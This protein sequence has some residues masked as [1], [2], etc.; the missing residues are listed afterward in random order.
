MILPVPEG[1]RIAMKR[2]GI[3]KINLYGCSLYLD[4]VDLAKARGVDPQGLDTRSFSNRALNPP[5]EDTITMGTNAAKAMLSDEDK[6]SIGLLIVGTST[7]VDF[8]KPISTNIHRALGLSPNV[9][10]YEI[11][12]GC[13]GGTAAVDAAVNWIASGTNHGKKALIIAT[14]SSRM[15]LGEEE[16]FSLGCGAVAMLV[17]DEPRIVEYELGKKGTWTQD[18]YDIFG[19]TP[20]NEMGNGALSLATY[21]DALEAAYRN[22]EEKAGEKIDFDTYF[23]HLIYHA[24]SPRMSFQAYRTHCHAVGLRQKSAIT[25]GYRSKVA[26]SQHYAHRTGYTYNAANFV[27]LCSL[28]R[29]LG[30]KKA[31]DRVGFFCYGSGAIGEF[32]SALIC[33]D[34]SGSLNPGI[35]NALDQRRRVSVD[36]YENIERSRQQHIDNPNFTPDF[37]L[38][39]GWYEE[40]YKGKGYLVLK[41]VRDFTRIY[42]GS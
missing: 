20:R 15:H 2:I 25:E 5:Y 11:K 39:N 23:A 3:E 41:Q 7:P 6:Q 13:Y 27:D 30:S 22:Y 29:N 35:E 12:H 31:G 32:S 19:P 18:V 37:S 10:N 24:P 14:D 42:E 21:L 36:E 38:P 1:W 28:I 26:P 8:G 34:A 33:A 40:H 9:R 17:S 16:E 4:Y